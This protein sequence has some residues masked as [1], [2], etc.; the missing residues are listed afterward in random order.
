MY[1]RTPSSLEFVDFTTNLGKAEKA[2]R[3]EILLKKI[4]R[5][6]FVKISNHYENFWVS[7][8]SISGHTD[9]MQFLGRVDNKLVIP[10]SYD[11]GDY[12]IFGINNVLHV[13]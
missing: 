13:L 3:A 4:Q 7:I 5:N 1:T 9:K 12:I 6:S 11:L 10:R 8:V 2:A